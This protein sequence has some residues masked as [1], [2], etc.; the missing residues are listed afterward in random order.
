[1]AN[2]EVLT[3]APYTVGCSVE[4]KLHEFKEDTAN[5]KTFFIEV[6]QILN[7]SKMLQKL[8]CAPFSSSILEVL[9]A[10]KTVEGCF[11]ST[12]MVSSWFTMSQTENHTTT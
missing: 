10:I 8:I 1:M 12:L 4:V 3:N 9:S 6:N 5:Q 2:N 7:L 11:T